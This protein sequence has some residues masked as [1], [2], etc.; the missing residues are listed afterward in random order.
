MTE[1]SL[2]GPVKRFLEE[3]GFTVKGEIG[4]CDVVG[5]AAGEPP[6]VV[7]S[8]LKLAFNLELVLQG[9]DR[10]TAGDEIWLAAPLS[11]RGR[12]READPRFRNLCRRL[13]F[14][15]LGIT[16]T[17]DVE[18][19]VA[20]TAPMPATTAA[21]APASSTSTAGAAATPP[22]ADPPARRS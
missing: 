17:G 2:Y 12:G 4:S 22:S 3:R 20:P 11:V 7:I 1:T 13:G 16:R 6:V 14:G 18:L 5:L 10:A 19:L 8:E 9:V 15:L 21:A